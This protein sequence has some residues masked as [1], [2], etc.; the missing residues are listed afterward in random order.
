MKGKSNW[1]AI[2]VALLATA[3]LFT[4]CGAVGPAYTRATMRVYTVDGTR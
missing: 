1:K 3:V 2:I 4:A